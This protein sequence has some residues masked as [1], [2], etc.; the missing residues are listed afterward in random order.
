[1]TTFADGNTTLTPASEK[2]FRLYAEDADN[3]SGEPLV[4]GNVRG[5]KAR[6]GNL[7]DLK[8]KGLITTWTEER[9]GLNGRAKTPLVWLN[10]T[11]LGIE[12]AATLGIDL[13]WI[14]A[15]G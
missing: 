3:W 4:G 10:F 12:Y 15:R 1:M 5:S 14:H 7:T 8:V 9:E 2:V 13:S 11:A 6:N